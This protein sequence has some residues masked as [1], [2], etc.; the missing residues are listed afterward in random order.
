MLIGRIRCDFIE[1]GLICFIKMRQ[2]A[3]C[4]LMCFK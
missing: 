2:N 4:V 3:G 1:T